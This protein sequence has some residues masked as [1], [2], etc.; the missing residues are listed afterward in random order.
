[1]HRNAKKVKHGPS[2]SQNSIMPEDHVVSF[3]LN[4]MMKNSSFLKNARRKFEIPMPAAMPCRLQH[5]EICG[6]VGHHRTKYAC[7][8]DADE[9]RRI[10]M[11][12]S[13]SK[14]HE[15]HIAGKGINSLSHYNLVE[16][17]P[18]CSFCVSVISKNSEL[19]P[20]FQKI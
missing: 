11:E 3:L 4:Q 7:N 12:E 9:S 13:Q 6:T 8:V 19:E 14:N 2:R 18:Y 15:D 16:Q 17:G 20:Q 1:M 5:R 10:R